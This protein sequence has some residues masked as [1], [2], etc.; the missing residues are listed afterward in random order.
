[1]ENIR[2]GIR[3]VIECELLKLVEGM[4]DELVEEADGVISIGVWEETNWVT[5][6]FNIIYGLWGT[7]GLWEDGDELAGKKAVRGQIELF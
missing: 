4:T 3:T 7:S 6:L 5:V 2:A 1:M